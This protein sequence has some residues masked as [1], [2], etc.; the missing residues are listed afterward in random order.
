[1]EAMEESDSAQKPELDA[2]FEGLQVYYLQ[3]QTAT[4]PAGTGGDRAGVCSLENSRRALVNDFNEFI[5]CLN[6]N[7]VAE[8]VSETIFVGL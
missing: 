5:H 1:M 6:V 3:V 8:V 7:T 4:L 2:I